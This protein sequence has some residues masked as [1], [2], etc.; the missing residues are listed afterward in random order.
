M[1]RFAYTDHEIVETEQD[2]V[3]DAARW[4]YDLGIHRSASEWVLRAQDVDGGYGDVAYFPGQNGQVVI[5]E[6]IEG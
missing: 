5:I 1:T 6:H 2:T 4:A 3:E